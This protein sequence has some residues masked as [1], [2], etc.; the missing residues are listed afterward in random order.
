VAMRAA[1]AVVTTLSRTS[2]SRPTFRPPWPALTA[3]NHHLPALRR[4]S[5]T[6]AALKASVSVKTTSSEESAWRWWGRCPLLRRR[7]LIGRQSTP[8]ATVMA[9]PANSGPWAVLFR[10][11]AP[12]TSM[13]TIIISIVTAT[14]IS[15][16]AQMHE[17]APNRPQRAAVPTLWHRGVCCLRVIRI[18]PLPWTSPPSLLW[19]PC[20][21]T[22]Q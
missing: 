16:I 3:I 19:H 10:M 9:G 1:T 6:A 11:R 22:L 12:T 5:I 15:N 7:H 2:V 13:P 17:T 18:C 20:R 4:G 14:T 21:K 8:T